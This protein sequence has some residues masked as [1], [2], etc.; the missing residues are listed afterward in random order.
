MVGA[1]CD[2]H[3]F[4]HFEELWLTIWTHGLHGSSGRRWGAYAWHHVPNVPGMHVVNVLDVH[5]KE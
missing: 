2:G 3:A 1:E 5:C 4:M